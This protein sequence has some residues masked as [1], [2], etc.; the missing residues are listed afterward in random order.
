MFLIKA[1]LPYG[2]VVL[3]LLI[4]RPIP[5]IKMFLNNTINLSWNSILG[6]KEINSEWAI[7]YSPRLILT[8]AS[9]IAL[10]VQVKS[11]KLFT[12]ITKYI[13]ST[14]MKTGLTYQCLPIL[15]KYFQDTYQG[16][17]YLLVN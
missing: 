3:L 8:I 13:F 12:P 15:L 10:A 17:G 2:I 6:F 14:I 11:I 5:I 9:F 4:S 1:W 7:L 16:C